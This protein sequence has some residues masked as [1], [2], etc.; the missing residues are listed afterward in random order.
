MLIF[1][2]KEIYYVDARKKLHLVSKIINFTQ[3]LHSS[4][5]AAFGITSLSS[6]E[7]G[8]GPTRPDGSRPVVLVGH[9][10]ARDPWKGWIVVYVNVF[11]DLF[12]NTIYFRILWFFNVFMFHPKIVFFIWGWS[13]IDYSTHS[14]ESF[15]TTIFLA[16]LSSN[17]GSNTVPLKHCVFFI[18]LYLLWL[19]SKLRLWQE[20]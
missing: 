20:Y 3:F 12:P 18:L 10:A 6:W 2:L 16:V 11:S 5:K 7:E 17:S 4:Q 14:P 1:I 15:K 19:F 9:S 8:S 13:N